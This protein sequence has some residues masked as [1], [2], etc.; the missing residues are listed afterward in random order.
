MSDPLVLTFGGQDIPFALPMK[1]VMTIEREC[2]DRSIVTMFEDMNAGIGLTQDEGQARFVGAG[3]V[4]IRDVYQIIRCAAI[5]GGMSPN[6]AGALVNEY[7][8]G[9]PYAETVPVA[10][11]ILS[12]TILGVR[13]KKKEG[14][15][16]SPAPL[17]EEV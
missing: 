4:R 12:A 15:A 8:D 1:W 17:T 16:A 10:W 6:D 2:G 13:L 7:V 9:R 14:E 3:S 5:G 11:A